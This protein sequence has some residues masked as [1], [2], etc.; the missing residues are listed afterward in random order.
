MDLNSARHHL[1]NY[2]REERDQ[3]LKLPILFLQWMDIET[4]TMCF[5]AIS[6]LEV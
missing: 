6:Q 5:A 4:S 2:D 1:S 3:D